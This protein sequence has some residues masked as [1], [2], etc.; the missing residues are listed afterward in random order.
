METAISPIHGA[1]PSIAA[2]IDAAPLFD[3]DP[4]Q[5]RAR[6][7][8]VARL[9]LNNWRSALRAHGV[10]GSSLAACAPAFEHERLE[11]ALAL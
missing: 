2:A 3:I 9:L 8:S 6:A 10:T 5:A 11:T 1:E 7:R 4:D